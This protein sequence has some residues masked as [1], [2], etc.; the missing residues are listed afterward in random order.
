MPV[1]LGKTAL[2]AIRFLMRPINNTLTK[3]FKHMNGQ[4]DSRGYFF[5]CWLGQFFNRFEV[6]MNRII[7]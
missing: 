2:T 4:K 5:F 7:I 1:P 6:T 3:N